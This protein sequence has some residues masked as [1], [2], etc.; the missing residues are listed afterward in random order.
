MADERLGLLSGTVTSADLQA[1]LD[2][3]YLAVDATSFTDA[4]RVLLKSLL[5]EAIIT[6]PTNNYQAMT[7]KSFYNSVMTTDRNGVNRVSTN[8]EVT[9]KSTGTVLL[10]DQQGL[11]QTQWKV[12]WFRF[13]GPARIVYQNGMPEDAIAFEA[14]YSGIIPL[15]GSVV[16]S[17]IL[18]TSKRFDLIYC[19]YACVAG[20]PRGYGTSTI[21]YTGAEVLCP[22]NPPQMLALVL[23]ADGKT[24]FVRN[25]F[26]GTFTTKISI[27]VNAIL[28]DV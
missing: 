11:M 19:T 28:Q 24:L 10:A 26:S 13:N 5:T 1:L 15:S 12:D 20:V 3:L 22:I 8:D 18:S 25:Y 6:N 9:A 7:P 4:K 16:L 2:T 14:C 17:P 23:S 27:H 21:I